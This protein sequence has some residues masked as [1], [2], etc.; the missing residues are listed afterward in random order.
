MH[1]YHNMNISNIPLH[2]LREVVRNELSILYCKRKQPIFE[3]EKDEEKY[4]SIGFGKYKE[5]GKEKQS[6]SP[7]FKKDDNGKYVPIEI[8]SK[9]PQVK[10]GSSLDSKATS[11]KPSTIKKKDVSNQDTPDGESPESAARKV[12]YTKSLLSTPEPGSD[13]TTKKQEPKQDDWKKDKDGW[14]ILD[15]D[16]AKVENI[17]DY[18]DKEYQEETGEY[19]ENDITM[20]VAPKAFKDRNDMIQKIKAA[21]P[22]FLSSEEMQNMSNTDVGDILSASEDGGKEAMLKLG[23]ERAKEYGKDWNRL[24]K[25]IT[26]NSEVPAPLALRDKNGNLHLL[27]GNTRMMSFT[28]SGK[29]LPVKVIDYD[30]D[31][32]YEIVLSVNNN[33]GENLSFRNKGKSDTVSEDDVF[34]VAQKAGEITLD[35]QLALEDLITVFGPNIPRYEFINVLEEYDMIYLANDVLYTQPSGF[36]MNE[37]K[38]RKVIRNI[39]RETLSK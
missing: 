24:E 34:E 16:R 20:K 29:K 25:G 3:N 7:T 18:S 1:M 17:R 32:Q 13:G 8:D 26:S 4:I 15:D 11:G 35:A 39:I 28:A 10:K 23:K 27:A 37:T 36:S 14:E 19:F 38:L 2:V 21:K 12:K 5:K 6:D 31:F 30:G 22:I 33:I 9:N